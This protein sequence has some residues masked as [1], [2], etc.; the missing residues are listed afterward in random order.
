MTYLCSNCG[1]E[2]N[3][4]GDVDTRECPFCQS[5]K[6]NHVSQPLSTL[7]D[8]DKFRVPPHEG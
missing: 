1:Q 4:S 6:S 7:S 3:H 5:D 2:F 8:Y